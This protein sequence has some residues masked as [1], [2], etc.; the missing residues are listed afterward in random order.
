MSFRFSGST[1]LLLLAI[2]SFTLPMI[3]RGAAPLQ[4]RTF[5]T[6]LAWPIFAAGA[7]VW[8]LVNLVRSRSLQAIIEIGLA[9]I[10]IWMYVDA[11]FLMPS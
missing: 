7:L 2:V 1:A 4:V 6:F 3:I 9:A 8:A 10:L 5:F 11:V